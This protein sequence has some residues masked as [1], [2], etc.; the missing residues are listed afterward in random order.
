VL[1]RF[2]IHP[3]LTFIICST[4]GNL[5]PVEVLKGSQTDSSPARRRGD[6]Q[7][8]DQ[9]ALQW[10]TRE[11]DIMLY[12][13]SPL[14]LADVLGSA[15]GRLD[16]VAD[17]NNPPAPATHMGDTETST[18]QRKVKSSATVSL[19]QRRQ[20]KHPRSRANLLT[21]HSQ[22]ELLEC[23]KRIQIENALVKHAGVRQLYL[24]AGFLCWTH[25]END[26][27]VRRAPLLF[28]PVT[29]VRKSSDADER[30]ESLSANSPAAPSDEDNEAIEYE[31]RLESEHP[32]YNIALREWCLENTEFELPEYIQAQ[33]L[34]DFF[35][36]FAQA[37]SGSDNIELQF[38][39]ALGN[40]APPAI[41]L[42]KGEEPVKLPA[43][44]EHFDTLL[45]M[46]ITGNKSLQ[47][48]NSVLNLLKNYSDTTSSPQ[49]LPSAANE[50]AGAVSNLHEYSKKLSSAGLES[51][52]FQHLAGL[53]DNISSW[54]STV[55]KAMQS[56]T[57]T[58]VIDMP[59]INAR[60]LIRLAG[61]IELIDKAP[62]TI[63]Q[64]KHADLCFSATPGLLQRAQHQA[65]LIEDELSTL[66]NTFVLDKV[67]AK[68][69]LLSLINELG[70]NLDEGP[71]IVDADYFNARRQF[72]EF[73]IEKPTNLTPEHRNL[74][75]K[76]AKVLRFR[77]LFV[78]NTEYRLALGPGYRGLRTDWVALGNAGEY[79][80]EISEVLESESIAAAAMGQWTEFRSTYVNELEILQ[81]AAQSLRKL[82]WICGS[83]WQTR[84]VNDVSEHASET[85]MK[86]MAWSEIYGTV[87]DSSAKSPADVLAQF[88]GRSREDVLTEIHVGETQATID[89][90][91]NDSGASAD[92]VFET[93]EW[94]RQAS[95]TASELQLEITAIVDHL[96]IA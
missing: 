68:K 45:A 9:R 94:L 31:I 22:D 27:V 88:S 76:L 24:T 32:E 41:G 60:H 33:P 92:A 51:V 93:I 86:L 61:I 28:Y 89:E 20:R 70:G 84:S 59:T 95:E 29:L 65:R 55:T 15:E 83:E 4:D 52:E 80:Q 48:L 14:A 1:A 21:Q 54:V 38:D 23:C 44:P 17:T 30:V 90:H 69:Q 39:M 40:A 7:E 47:Q 13:H 12:P 36:Q 10:S 79:A 8:A 74:L 35:A 85:R 71:D 53:P 72:M 25:E 6:Q 46:A 34:Q 82:L 81:N 5:H 64:F 62:M 96:Q 3:E 75:G 77:E 58:E 26:T 11:G 66:Q 42:E 18:A 67:P 63:E 57:I 73:S 50:A 87:T 91:I 2:L 16:L 78:N 49:Q 19:Q 43:L 56:H 37:I